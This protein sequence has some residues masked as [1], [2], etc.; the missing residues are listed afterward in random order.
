MLLRVRAPVREP[1]NSNTLIRNRTGIDVRGP[2]TGGRDA[3][4]GEKQ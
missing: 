1:I 4:K 3:E 2:R